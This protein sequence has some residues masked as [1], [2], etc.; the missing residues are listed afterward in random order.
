MAATSVGGETSLAAPTAPTDEAVTSE[1]LRAGSRTAAPESQDQT[2]NQE[3]GLSGEVASSTP[4][5]GASAPDV[6]STPGTGATERGAEGRDSD[7]IRILGRSLPSG[8][9]AAVVTARASAENE[10]SRDRS[11]LEAN[12]PSLQAPAGLSPSATETEAGITAV[13]A[14]ATAAGVGETTGRGG[15]PEAPVTSHVAAEMPVPTG[16]SADSVVDRAPE[17]PVARSRRYRDM[18]ARMP[19][20]DQS[21]NTDPGP[22]PPLQLTG[23]ADPGR[24]ATQAA[25]NEV[26]I[27]SRWNEARQGMNEDEGVDNIYPTLPEEMLVAPIS[28]SGGGIRQVT[29]P[30]H[31]NLRPGVRA[32]MD[33]GLG[34]TWSAEIA[35]AESGHRQAMDERTRA[36]TERRSETDREIAQLEADAVNEQ[37]GYRSQAHTD[38]ANARAG[39]Q[40]EIDDARTSYDG[41]RNRINRDLDR[42]VSA[43]VTQAEG[44]AER[45]LDAGQSR[46]EERRRATETEAERRRAEAERRRD[47]ADGFFDWVA[48]RVKRFFRALQEGL[49]ILFD[50]LRAAVKTIIEGAKRL[51]AAAIELGRR[52]VVGLIRTAGRALEVAADVFLAAFPAARDRAKALIREG[53]RRAEDA[54]NRAAEALRAGV[55]ALLDALGTALIFILDVFEAFYSALFSALEF[56]VV[57]FIEVQRAL[58]RLDLAAQYAPGEMEGQIYEEM[59]GAD[60]TQPLAFE[61]TPREIADWEAGLSGGGGGFVSVDTNTFPQT[62]TEVEADPV[63]EFDP[64]P[65]LLQRLDFTRGPVEFEGN[66]EPGNSLADL[67]AETLDSEAV[68][69]SN[70]TTAD[71]TDQEQTMGDGSPGSAIPGETTDEKLDHYIGQAAPQDCRT[72]T[73]TAPEGPPMP[74]SAKI[75]PLTR[76]QRARYMLNQ[77]WTGIKHWARCNWPIILAAVLAA[78]I[79]IA[80]IVAIVVLSGGTVGVALTGILTAFTGA[81]IIYAIA[82]AA[83]FLGEYLQKSIDGDIIG[84]AKG[85]AR[86]FAVAA[87]E[88]IF[89]VLTYVTAGAFRFVAAGIKG[90]G[91]LAAG[92]A[93]GAGRLATAAARQTAR[94]ARTAGRGAIRAGRGALRFTGRAVRATGRV[95]SAVVRRG[96]LVIRNVRNAIGRGAK[97][98]RDLGRR[99]GRRLP[100]RRYRIIIRRRWLV[101]QGS[102]NPWVDIAELNASEWVEE[103]S[104]NL[105][106]S[107]RRGRP[108]SGDIIRGTTETGEEVTGRVFRGSRGRPCHRDL[109]RQRGLDPDANVIHHAIE[110]QVLKRFKGVFTRAEIN[111]ISR[112]R[113]IAKGTYNAR[114]HLSKIRRLWD[115]MYDAIRG[116]SLSVSQQRRALTQYMQHVDKFIDAMQTFSQTNRAFRA[117]ERAGNATRMRE[118]LDAEIARLMTQRR[119]DTASVIDRIIRG[120]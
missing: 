73:P 54:V 106:A 120:L 53:T 76:T 11:A 103:V 71:G 29:E 46:A 111:S 84:G 99:L 80:A 2:A 79:A 87:V 40:S 110:Q 10:V 67:Y 48:S 18:I 89:A 50:G 63:V 78:V 47:E 52:A 90:A 4:P 6:G 60:I 30:D 25:M 96:R 115:Q 3:T 86:A 7:A 58:F 15:K 117:A 43:R 61:A 98:V 109:A 95:G 100:F 104:E 114:V 81:M 57:G 72:E 118:L 45:H 105:T 64:E 92:A 68:D 93:R 24:I 39:W 35:N 37:I 8:A 62:P 70:T 101:L 42:D 91:R 38:V 16:P 102:I 66:T 21:V 12:P 26:T 23:E 22:A 14:R 51:A 33:Q 32:G 108:R 116:A 65:E 36:E 44:E 56:L 34:P 74:L 20:S 113:A 107:G 82:R 28:Q 83:G 94:G 75:G 17:D 97:S 59:I 31:P 9:G 85:L 41:E 69:S 88:I 13:V 55:F 49:K 119:F 5:P 77:A 27:G 19:V 112:F 1:T